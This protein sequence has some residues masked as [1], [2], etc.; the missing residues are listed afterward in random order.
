M[1][2]ISTINMTGQDIF[3]RKDIKAS[4]YNQIPIF[5]PQPV[6]YSRIRWKQESVKLRIIYEATKPWKAYS[7]NDYLWSS[8]NSLKGGSDFCDPQILIDLAGGINPLIEYFLTEN[9]DSCLEVETSHIIK[10][11]E[12]LRIIQKVTGLSNPLDISKLSKESRNDMLS[13]IKK[14]GIPVRQLSRLTG[15]DRNIIQRA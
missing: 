15:I 14:E 7:S 3:S 2:I 6:I 8:W 4:R 1:F 11:D 5:W 13:R 10:E 12:A 9:T